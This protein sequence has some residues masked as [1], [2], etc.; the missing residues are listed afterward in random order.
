MRN[1]A[2]VNDP[3]AVGKILD[4]IGESTRLPRISPVR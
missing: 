2:F 1:V 4:N 3:A